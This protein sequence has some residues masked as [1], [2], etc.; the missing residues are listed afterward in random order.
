MRKVTIVVAMVVAANSGVAGTTPKGC[1]EKSWT[2]AE[3]KKLP[4]QKVTAIRLEANVSKQ[5]ETKPQAYGRLMARFRET[6]DL[7]LSTSYECN[8]TGAGYACASY[9]DGTIFV[10]SPGNTGMQ[11]TPPNGVG[12]FSEEC[13]ETSATLQM[14]ADHLPFALARRGSKACPT[15]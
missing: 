6:G 1:Y 14:N 4:L 11:I 2:K 3:L 8:D 9:C 13:G 15:R 7:W 10:L 5:P 12:V